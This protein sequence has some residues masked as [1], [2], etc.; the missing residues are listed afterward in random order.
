MK[1]NIL[2]NVGN[3]VHE[4][5]HSS[6]PGKTGFHPEGAPFYIV[7]DTDDRV[8][9]YHMQDIIKISMDVPKVQIPGH[10]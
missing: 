8:H 2:F 10:K 3:E 6:M 4:A 5:E 9:Y 7:T 1:V